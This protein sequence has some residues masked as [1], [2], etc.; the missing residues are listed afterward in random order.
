LST[1]FSLNNDF[2]GVE[3]TFMF[4]MFNFDHRVGII[5]VYS[6][7]LHLYYHYYYYY[8]YYYIMIIIIIV[9]VYNKIISIQ[10]RFLWE[11]R[12]EKRPI[13][14]VSWET[15]CKSWEEGGLGIKDVRM[16]NNAL[17]AKWK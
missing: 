3:F 5:D 12:S 1:A 6:F 8:Y 11:W 13:S 14:W 2:L 17:L 9:S 7:I 4:K 15:K 10:R 16:F